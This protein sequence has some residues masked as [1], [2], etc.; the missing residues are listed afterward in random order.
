MDI[1]LSTLLCL[2]QAQTKDLKEM[3]PFRG[4]QSP[5]DIGRIIGAAHIKVQVDS[6]KSL[7][8]LAPYLLKLEAKERPKLIAK[9]IIIKGFIIPST[10]LVTL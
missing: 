9:R 7:P 10:A 6:F 5:T 2:S 8:Q 3:Q 1:D 4:T